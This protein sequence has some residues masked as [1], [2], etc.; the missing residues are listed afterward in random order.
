[1]ATLAEQILQAQDIQTHK[2]EVPEW[3]VTVY[4]KV[5]KGREL[6]AFQASLLVQGNARAVNIE[7]M[8]AKFLVRCLVDEKG[9]R[10]F[11]DD[12]AKDLAEKSG[13]VLQRLFQL[14]QKLNGLDDAETGIVLK[15]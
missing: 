3:G 11:T 4:V 5:L 2:V 10:I 13:G 9:G 8:R 15:N 6:D 14:A 12:E 7:N 1:M